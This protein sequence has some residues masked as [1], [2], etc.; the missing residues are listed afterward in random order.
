MSEIIRPSDGAARMAAKLADL[1]RRLAAMETSRRAELATIASGHLRVADG[2]EGTIAEFGIFDVVDED[3]GLEV[4]RTGINVVDPATDYVILRS[5]VEDGFTSPAIGYG[6]VGYDDLWR[7]TTSATFEPLWITRGVL[8]P[9][10]GLITYANISLSGGTASWEARLKI[11]TTTIGTAY[12]ATIS[13]STSR[14]VIWRLDMTAL[15]HDR[16]ADFGIRVDFEVR[17]TSGTDPVWCEL[18]YPITA[19]DATTKQASAGGDFGA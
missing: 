3:T 8:W 7:S 1:E 16:V 19:Y 14:S 5:S 9:S 11:A 12:S 2:D 15:G 10:S 13:G 18:P 17:R 4:E 6:W